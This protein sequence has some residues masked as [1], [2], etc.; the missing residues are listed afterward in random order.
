MQKFYFPFSEKWSR[1]AGVNLPEAMMGICAGSPNRWTIVVSG[2]FLTKT[3][4]YSDK[5]HI[6]DIQSQEWYTK[7]WTKLHYGPIMD[8]TC[9]TV[10][11]Q[12]EKVILEAGGYNGSALSSTQMFDLETKR[13]IEFGYILPYGSRSAV[14]AELGKK[15]ILAGG[16]K[17]TGTFHEKQTCSRSKDVLSLEQVVVQNN[18]QAFWNILPL[19]LLQPKSS[20][21]IMLV[22]K[23]FGE[24]CDPVDP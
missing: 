6:F 7:P 8:A 3:N 17:C 16:V 24:N 9:N 21:T 14:L 4:D 10:H 12:G 15:P 20:H 11:W 5:A 1:K 2:G 22:P 19:A 18:S 13:L 23:T